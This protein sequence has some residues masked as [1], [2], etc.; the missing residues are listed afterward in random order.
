VTVGRLCHHR[1][2]RERD[3]VRYVAKHPSATS[4]GL[5]DVADPARA[6]DALRAAVA[7][8]CRIAHPDMPDA[9]LPNLCTAEL[10]AGVP[11]FGLDMQDRGGYAAE[12]V[13]IVLS[14]VA[15]SGVG[16]RVEPWEWPDPGYEH[17]HRADIL[18]ERDDLAEWQRADPDP[19]VRLAARGFAILDGRG[20]L[21]GFP[22]GFPVPDGVPVFAQRLPDGEHVAWRRGGGQFT[23]LPQRLREFGCELGPLPAGP[24]RE[25][26]D[27]RRFALWREGAGGSVSLYREAHRPGQPIENWY[28]SVVWGPGVDRPQETVDGPPPGWPGP[29]VFDAPA[30]RRLAT[31]LVSGEHVD[32]VVMLLALGEANAVLETVMRGAGRGQAGLRRLAAA[33]EPWIAVLSGPRRAALRH[34]AMLLTRNWATGGTTRRTPPPTLATDDDGFLYEAAKRPRLASV[35]APEQVTTVETAMA[36][37]EP[38]RFLQTFIQGLR[39]GRPPAPVVLAGLLTDLPPGRVAAAT[40]ACWQVAGR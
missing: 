39:D 7:A 14:C 30:A 25:A 16:G 2:V 3:L 24:Y 21:P 17:D 40:A 26:R 22:D 23:E 6:L 28:A 12:V 19:L 4:L 18:G 11:V 38:A 15:E 37:L 5:Y 29:V 32:G 31:S 8:V 36:V 20:L 34:C 27:M 9:S 35:L 1:P 10:R 13:R 33:M